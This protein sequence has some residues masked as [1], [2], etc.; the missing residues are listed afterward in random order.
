MKFHR[1][2]TLAFSM[3]CLSGGAALG[4]DS[5][6]DSAMRSIDGELVY[7]ADYEDKVLLIVNVAS[8]CG[9][10]GQYKQ[11]QALHEK[12]SGQ[13]LVVIGVPCNQFNNSEPGSESEIKRFC[14]TNYNVTFLMTRKEWVNGDTESPLYTYL[15]SHANPPGRIRWN[16]E[17][18]IVSKKG[19]VVGRFGPAIPPTAKSFIKMIEEELAK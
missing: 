13:G 14:S 11:L 10:A 2:W 6:Y 17:K 4:A 9:L 19:K 8:Q 16:F 15:K 7:L 1:F 12:Y 18:F 5:I 3:F